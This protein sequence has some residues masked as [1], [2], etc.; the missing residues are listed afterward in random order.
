M[1]F[2]AFRMLVGDRAKYLGLIF[3][4][5]FSTFLL[6]NQMSIFAGI[7]KRTGSQVLDVTEADI[8]VMHPKT[9]YFEQTQPLKDTD[10]DRVRNVSGVGF[11]VR[12]FKGSPIAKTLDGK[13]AASFTLG[14]DDA[15]LVGV[16]RKMLMGRW[17]DLRKAGAVVMDKAGY[18]LLYPGE[19]LGLGKVLELN[20]RK[21]TLV[22]I[23]DASAPFVSFPVI[24][25][26]YSE[27]VYFQGSQRNQ[28]AYVLV[29]AAPGM[30]VADLARRIEA[31][32]SLKA[33]TSMEFV[34][35]C[36]GYYLRN[37]GIPVNFGIT[38]AIALIVGLAVA[39]Q[40]FYLF[41]LEN[42]RQFGA[43]KAVGVTNLRL[44]GMVL[45]QSVT[46]GFI[47][48]ALGTGVSALFFDV[49]S[50]QVATRGIVLLAP[51]AGIVALLMSGVILLVSV[52]S[53]RKVLVLEPASVF[54]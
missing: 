20:D 12:M 22:G 48:F 51:V 19:P 33:R 17:E 16:P 4:F 28:M 13:F 29:K 25:A 44:V 37:T 26:R 43:L 47:G 8:W 36:I 15:T 53:I 38:I 41:T 14:V 54:R 11:G 42:L 6:E 9:E 27:A 32:T 21:V 46:S 34:W 50:K 7:M 31:V 45:L 18:S 30:P 24:H 2:I 49:M 1:N 3:A 5:A 10:L 40:T 39:G 35:D 23:S 52:I